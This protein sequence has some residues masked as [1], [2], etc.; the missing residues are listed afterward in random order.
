MA[1][2]GPSLSALRREVHKPNFTLFNVHFRVGMWHDVPCH[3]FSKNELWPVHLSVAHDFV[4]VSDR[5]FFVP[6]VPCLGPGHCHL[7]LV[8]HIIYHSVHQKHMKIL[9]NVPLKE[10]TRCMVII[11]L[12]YTLHKIQWSTVDL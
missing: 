11:V 5:A 1:K 3:A 12:S 9:F 8:V 6:A 7:Y 2:Q 10:V 4:H